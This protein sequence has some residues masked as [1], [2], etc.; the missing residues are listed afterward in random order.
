MEDKLG[1]EYWKIQRVSIWCWKEIKFEHFSCY[2]SLTI[3]ISGVSWRFLF[4]Q[5]VR[6]PRKRHLRLGGRQDH[7]HLRYSQ[8]REWHPWP[9]CL[10]QSEGIN[11]VGIGWGLL[12]AQDLLWAVDGGH[13]EWPFHLNGCLLN[14]ITYNL[15]N[16]V[17]ITFIIIGLATSNRSFARSLQKH[18]KNLF[19]EERL[20]STW[21]A[22]QTVPEKFSKTN[23]GEEFLVYNEVLN[24]DGQRVLGFMSPSILAVIKTGDEWS[25]DVLSTSENGFCLH[26]YFL[27]LFSNLT[28]IFFNIFSNSLILFVDLICSLLW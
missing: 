24:K 5:E 8:P 4:L 6:L 27:K 19:Q 15:L 10:C 20:S 9:P 14:F 23:S 17:F 28:L 11:K 16:N 22:L 1:Q 7:R 13:P 21:E 2:L 3:L 25:L 12:Q 26:R 18:R